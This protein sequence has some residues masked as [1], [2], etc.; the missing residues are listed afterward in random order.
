MAKLHKIGAVVVFS[1][2]LAVSTN[3]TSMTYLSD[4]DVYVFYSTGVYNFLH[5]WYVFITVRPHCLQCRAL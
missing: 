5:Q 4:I 2:I 1:A 3:V